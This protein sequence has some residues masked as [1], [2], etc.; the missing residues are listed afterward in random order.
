M[1][2]E[3]SVCFILDVYIAALV[4]RLGL[5]LAIYKF[6]QQMHVTFRISCKATSHIH[7]CSDT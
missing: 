6:N 4:H 3:C 1:A 2:N 5:K 7:S